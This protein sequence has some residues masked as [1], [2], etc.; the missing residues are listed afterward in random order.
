MEELEMNPFV[1]DYT[2]YTVSFSEMS[3]F[4]RKAWY[5]Y[6]YFLASCT[7]ENN[8][9]ACQSPCPRIRFFPL[10][11]YIVWLKSWDDITW[12]EMSA[13]AYELIQQWYSDNSHLIAQGITTNWSKAEACC[14]MNETARLLSQ[15]YYS[16]TLSVQ[17]HQHPAAAYFYSLIRR[18][19]LQNTANMKL[20]TIFMC[21]FN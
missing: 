18:A 19:A 3:V 9:C 17:H 2:E 20:W 10:F 16:T 12:N 13:E 5:M 14:D 4:K 11:I 7:A 6:I 8:V 1:A 21:D 15:L